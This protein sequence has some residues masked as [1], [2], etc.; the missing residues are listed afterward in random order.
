ME[1]KNSLQMLRKKPK[2]RRTR[3][4]KRKRRRTRRKRRKE[5]VKMKRNLFLPP[6]QLQMIMHLR[7]ARKLEP[8]NSVM[9]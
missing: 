3:R 7:R 9:G 2:R 1:A 5:R 8:T 4:T 6:L